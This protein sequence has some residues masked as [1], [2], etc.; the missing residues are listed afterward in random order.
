MRNLTK[1]TLGTVVGLIS[2]FFTTKALRNRTEAKAEEESVIWISDMRLDETDDDP[3]PLFSEGDFVYLV[4]PHTGGYWIGYSDIGEPVT[5]KIG[6]SYYD[7]EQ[8]TFRYKL[9][10]LQAEEVEEWDGEELWYA[11]EWLDIADKPIMKREAV[12]VAKEAEE[13]VAKSYEGFEEVFEESFAE[14]KATAI[15]YWLDVLNSEEEDE[16]AKGIARV[17]L[18]ELTKEEEAE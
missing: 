7:E 11:E 17:R 16:E 14:S 1:L 18:T 9:S 3:T 8:E 13:K 12:K 6:E 2:G 10:P 15:D 4:N 5:Y